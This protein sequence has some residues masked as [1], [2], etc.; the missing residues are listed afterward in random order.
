VTLTAEQA[1]AL[2]AAGITV[3]VPGGASAAL[4]DTAA[5]LE[6]TPAAQIAGLLAIG[7]SAIGAT[8]AS[9]SF[10]VDQTA[11]I[12]AANL[13]VSAP[14]GYT[15]TENFADGSQ[16]VLTF[17][18][19]G[20]V[21]SDVRIEVDGSR[22]VTIHGVMGQPYAS[23]ENVYDTNWNLTSQKL[24]NADGSI[25]QSETV[26]A[27][28]DG[29]TTTKHFDGAGALNSQSTDGPNGHDI[30]VYGVTGQPYASYENVYDAN[31]TLTSQKLFNADGTIYQSETVTANADGT[32][33]TK[34]FDGLGTLT[35]Q[36]IDGPS[37]HDI[38]VY[39]VT[40]QLYASYEN[41]YDASWNL[42]SQKLFNAD[43]SIYQSQTVTA[44]ADGTTTTR[45][46][47]GA[48]TLTSQSI[49]G[50]S[51]HDTTVYGVTGQPYASYE[52]V[53]DASWTLTSQKLFNSDGS[54]YQSQTVTAN[55]DGTTTTRHFDGAGALTSQ[56]INGPSGHDTTVYGVTGQPYT[57][58][59]NV[60]DAGWTLIAQ[61]LF[62]SDGSI[63]QS[64]TVAA[65]ADGST[66]T[67]HFDGSGALTS[68][69]VDGPNG[70]DVS[71]YG[72]SDQPYASY[73][74][75]YDTSWDLTA[76]KL[77]N[78]DGSIF[79]LQTVTANANGN[80]TT[81]HFDEVGALTSQSID[82]PSGHDTTVYGV[83]G[84]PYTSYENVYD[85]SWNLT[86]Q[87][88]FHSDGSISSGVSTYAFSTGHG[89]DTID[90]VTGTGTG[91]VDFTS[92][93]ATSQLW[94]EQAGNNLQI[95]IMGTNDALTIGDWFGGSNSAA[96]Q[97]FSTADGS[98]LDTQAGQ[99]VQAMATF[100]TNNPGFNPTQV[101]Q[102]PTD[103]N[104]QTAVAAAWHH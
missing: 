64:Q 85:T 6:S 91:S 56:S 11:A 48:G 17:G 71:V 103:T 101:S 55:A 78:A 96:V 9:V 60:Y 86:A 3:S 70:H 98:H 51:G 57:F 66:T 95:D 23:Y 19:G 104:L 37:G 100:A 25:Y 46:F 44:N 47:D 54:I 27:N 76:Q 36:S 102:M 2:E 22:T 33:T 28:A 82:G 39:G 10:T 42:T 72:V 35:S 16:A 99:L 32:T 43:G 59:E 90:A 87:S 12:I 77:F 31:W 52:N 81:K 79:Q 67:K 63:Y 83:T 29:T 21:S 15:V 93:I 94:F 5:N 88:L 65:N 62:N 80:T 24:F 58:Y 34:H 7:V 14:A 49:D 53:Y 13:S 61:K 68:Q 18:P 26:T 97:S 75:V 8:D 73:E 30:A 50:P 20:G 1:A 84:Q 38:A 40:E 45:H 92:G 69:S 89:R 41:V 4:S 74:N